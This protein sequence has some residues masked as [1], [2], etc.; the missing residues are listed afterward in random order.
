MPVVAGPV[1]LPNE[2]YKNEADAKY[3]LEYGFGV[4]DIMMGST[5]NAPAASAP[6]TNAIAA[7]LSGLGEILKPEPSG[8]T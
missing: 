8:S 6:R 1:P 7:F 3:D 2:L 5:A 4:H